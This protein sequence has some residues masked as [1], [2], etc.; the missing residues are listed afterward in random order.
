MM[1][2]KKD[3]PY[4]S[5]ATCQERM[6]AAKDLIDEKFNSLRNIIVATGATTTLIITAVAFA[7]RFWK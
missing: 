1:S 5:S 3:N 7:L 4:V 2:E 6:K